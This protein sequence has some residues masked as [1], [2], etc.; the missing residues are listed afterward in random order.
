MK[1]TT[2]RAKLKVGD[3]VRW[4]NEPSVNRKLAG[5]QGVGTVATPCI[6]HYLAPALPDVALCRLPG[7]RLRWVPIREL[8]IVSP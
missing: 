2:R 8:T 7:D 3:S 6:I 4:T 5:L 1:N